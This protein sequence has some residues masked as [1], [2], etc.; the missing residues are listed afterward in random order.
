MGLTWVLLI[1]DVGAQELVDNGFRRSAVHDDSIGSCIAEVQLES[2]DDPV[3][4]KSIAKWPWIKQGH[5]YI[6]SVD[7][8][9]DKIGTVKNQMIRA[10][11]C[12]TCHRFLNIYNTCIMKPEQRSKSPIMNTVTNP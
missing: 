5:Q 11:P 3:N 9:H 2:K 1:G 8:V 7:N 10:R 12:S 6:L 4:S